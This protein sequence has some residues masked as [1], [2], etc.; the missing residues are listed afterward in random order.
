MHG[1]ERRHSFRFTL[2]QN[3]SLALE[4]EGQRIP[5]LMKNFSSGGA[6]LCCDRSIKREER[7]GFIVK[8]PPEV[9]GETSRRVW[10]LGKVLRLEEDIT[11][12]QFGI[13][14]GFQRSQMLTDA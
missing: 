8:L 14:I 5:A 13:A 9:T 4:S 7:I 2:E 10:C 3:I 11:T 1:R 12:G 6:F